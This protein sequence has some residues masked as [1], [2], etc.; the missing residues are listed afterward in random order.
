MTTETIHLTFEGVCPLLMHSGRL[1]DPLDDIAIALAA[2]TSKRPKTR[3][4]H[5]RIA[6]LEWHGSLWLYGGRPCIPPEAIEAAFVGG[7][8]TRKKGLVARAGLVVNDPAILD[9]DGPSDVKK[10]FKDSSFRLRSLVRV[11]DSR[12]IRTRPRFP[13]WKVNVSATFLPSLLNRDEVLEY[14]RIAGS[15]GIGDWRP[16]YG[17]F[18][19]QER[20]LE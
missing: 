3:S 8:K 5:K 18:V 6:E 1:A 12:T 7:A 14:F 17:K 15:F 16:R 13:L 20:Q 10:L 9:Y 2:V 19:V 4:D 11:R